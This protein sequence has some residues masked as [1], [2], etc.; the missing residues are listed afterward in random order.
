VLGEVTSDVGGAS[1]CGLPVAEDCLDVTSPP[2]RDL[3][4]VPGHAYHDA[5][6][7][8]GWEHVSKK[9][10]EPT[11]VADEHRCPGHDGFDP[12]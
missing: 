7:V 2:I 1:E 4:V 11:G 9:C 10:S 6:H 5:P 12:H 3:L 8:L